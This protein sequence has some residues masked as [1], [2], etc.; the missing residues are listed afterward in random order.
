MRT[1]EETRSTYVKLRPKRLARLCA[2]N[3][4]TSPHTFYTLAKRT[5]STCAAG[6][7]LTRL[8]QWY[9]HT[10]KNAFLALQLRESGIQTDLREAVNR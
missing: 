10:K 2:S 3:K 9:V 7:R 5:Q 6:V 4:Y 1:A 8:V